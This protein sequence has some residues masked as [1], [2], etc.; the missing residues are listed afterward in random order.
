M[1]CI[2]QEEVTLHIHTTYIFSLSL[3]L[4][5]LRRGCE[6]VSVESTLKCRSHPAHVQRVLSHLT[7]ISPSLKQH[8]YPP[9]PHYLYLHP[10]SQRKF[11]GRTPS[12]PRTEV[13]YCNCG[14]NVTQHYCNTTIS[15]LLNTCGERS[16]L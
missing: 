1:R 13:Q 9:T 7:L 4:S 15:Y 5:H 3:T 14:N 11:I 12:Q 8:P 10:K 6:Y 16:Y 2:N